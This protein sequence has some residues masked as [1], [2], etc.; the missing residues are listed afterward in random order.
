MLKI[1]TL[2][3]QLAPMKHMVGQLKKDK[4][5]ASKKITALEGA[6]DA[7]LKKIQTTP[8]GEKD[9]NKIYESLMKDL[10]KNLGDMKKLLEKQKIAEEQERLRKIQEEMEREKKRKEEEE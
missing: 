1:K 3:E 8:V 2:Y 5:S 6:M 7:A 10:E 9:I 4:D